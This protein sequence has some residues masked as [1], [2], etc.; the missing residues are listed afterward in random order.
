MLMATAATAKVDGGDEGGYTD[1]QEALAGTIRMT[2]IHVRAD[3][4]TGPGQGI[5][6]A[7]LYGCEVR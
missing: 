4:R 7:D 5:D 3:Q 1:V 6:E 2:R